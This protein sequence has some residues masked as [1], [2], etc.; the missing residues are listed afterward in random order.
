MYSSTISDLGTRRKLSVLL[1]DQAALT[2][3]KEP[4]VPIVQEAG[5][6]P[7]LVWTVWSREKPLALARNRTP[8]VQPGLI[9]CWFLVRVREKISFYCDQ[10][11]LQLII[12]KYVNTQNHTSI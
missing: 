9:V 11:Q 1:H 12:N 5:W 10:Q 4:P 7:E 2:P 8:A 6:A 3:G